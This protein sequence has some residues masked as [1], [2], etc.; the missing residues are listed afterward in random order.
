MNQCLHKIYYYP[1]DFRIKSNLVS[2]DS[3]A[4]PP[5]RTS[6]QFPNERTV[7]LQ[8]GSHIA[9]LMYFLLSPFLNLSGESHKDGNDSGDS[10]G[11]DSDFGDLEDGEEGDEGKR[12]KNASQQR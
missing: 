7:F 5:H 2:Y 6:Y 1:E 3:S 8:R 4:P 12:R 9:P 10:S 11:D